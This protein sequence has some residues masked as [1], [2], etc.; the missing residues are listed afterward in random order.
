VPADYICQTT[1]INRA[2]QEV[3]I[4]L[5]FEP[6]IRDLDRLTQQL[7][8]TTVGTATRPAVMPMDV[9]REGDKFLVE[10]DLPGINPA[11]IDVSVEQGALTVRAQRPYAGEES[12]DW[13]TA[14]RTHGVFSRQLFLGDQLDTDHIGAD[15][16]DGVLRLSIPVAQ[17]A[18]P[19]KL[20]ITNG[21]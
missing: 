10:L 19:R 3:M 4:M 13:V 6:L 1:Q 18:K 12:R 5:G 16:T 20:A 11:S 15:Y 21:V 17:Q 7:W 2:T 8:G 9:W 14:E